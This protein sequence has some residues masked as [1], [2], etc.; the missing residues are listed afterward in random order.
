MYV[1]IHT[2]M[3]AYTLT[4]RDEAAV[5]FLKIDMNQDGM[6]VC[7]CVC[8][9]IRTDQHPR[10]YVCKQMVCVYMCVCVCM[11]VCMYASMYVHDLLM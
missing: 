4:Q 11:Y 9:Y 1:Y 8:M 6:Y 5:I 7:M 10:K 2:Y 3:H